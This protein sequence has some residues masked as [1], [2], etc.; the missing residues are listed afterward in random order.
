MNAIQGTY[1]DFKIVKSRGVAQFIIEVPIEQ[2]NQAINHFGLPDSHLEKWV[3]IAL[4]NQR[5][6]EQNQDSIS[7]VQQAGILCKS[8]HFGQYLKEEIGVPEVIPDDEGSV[9]QGLR[10]ILGIKSRTEFHDNVDA[11]KSW[12][13]IKSGYDSWSMLDNE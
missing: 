8:A 6:I 9:T 5:V 12:N 7:A 2:A 3:A 11:L 13:R 4:L 10:A 1:A